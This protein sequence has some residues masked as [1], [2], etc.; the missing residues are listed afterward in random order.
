MRRHIL[1]TI[2]LAIF[3]AAA[4]AIFALSAQAQITPE[5]VRGAGFPVLF[6]DTLAGKNIG[7]NDYVAARLELDGVSTECK[8]RGRGNT[9]WETRELYKKPYLLKLGEPLPLLGMPPARKWVLV[10]NAADKA[11]I[12]N[13]YALLVLS[14][15]WGRMAWVPQ[16]RPVSLFLNGKYNGS[17]MLFEKIEVAPGRLELPHGSFLAVV[18]SRQNKEWNFVTSRGTKVSLRMDAAEEEYISMQR[19]VQEAE[20]AIFGDGGGDEQKIDVASF[21]DWY[22]VNELTKNHDAKFQASCYFYYDADADKIF[23]GPPWDFDISCGNI[24]WDGCQN[25]EGFWVRNDQWY[26]RLFEDEAFAR[27][28][29]ERWQETRAQIEDS[30][31]WIDEEAARLSAFCELNDAV[32]RTIGHRQWPHAPG[33]KSRKTYESEVAYMKDF[34]QKRAA[35]LDD[36]FAHGAADGQAVGSYCGAR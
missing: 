3:S 16:G 33:W 20:D 10:A 8:I 2:F 7:R 11:F 5:T 19:R 18:N 36:A 12:R 6:V 27:A 26:A 30:F 34:L 31:A 14:K 25:P 15:I 32:W 29:K 1:L 23:M 9:T 17:Y 24:S 21:V 28:V 13:S 22:L 35:W 4:I